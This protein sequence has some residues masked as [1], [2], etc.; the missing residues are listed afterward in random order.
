MGDL[1]TQKITFAD[2]YRLLE[3]ARASLKEI[4][5][6]APTL[7]ATEAWETVSATVNEI[8]VS[9]A[10]LTKCGVAIRTL[11]ESV[12]SGGPYPGESAGVSP[13]E[14]LGRDA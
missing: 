5:K 6:S 4:G 12:L 9:A 8:A 3:T 10:I 2:I 11:C 1:N 14:R 7:L 13:L